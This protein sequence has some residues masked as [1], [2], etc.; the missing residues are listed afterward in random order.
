MLKT[1]QAYLRQVI[2]REHFCQYLNVFLRCGFGFVVKQYTPEHN[3]TSY[4]K[5]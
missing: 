2:E 4:R 5:L 3:P 1:R